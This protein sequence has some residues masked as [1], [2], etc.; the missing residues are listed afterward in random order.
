LIANRFAFYF[1]KWILLK[2]GDT[3]AV[4]SF[5]TGHEKKGLANCKL[6]D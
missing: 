5:E 1:K 2:P 3:P 6:T 4:T